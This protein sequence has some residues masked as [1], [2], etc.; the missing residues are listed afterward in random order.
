MKIALP[1]LQDAPTPEQLKQLRAALD[2]IV[3]N[4]RE[5]ISYLYSLDAFDWTILILYFGILMLLAILGTIRLRMVYQFWRYRNIKP[6]P[7]HRYK[8]VE[9]PRITVQLPLFNE[10]YVA[11][12][13]IDSI[14]SLDYPR[15][16]IEIQVLD[17]ST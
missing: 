12:R 1:L 2:P 10:L 3:R 16:L 11:E 7:L 8:E 5:N 9:L 13:L 15:N 17:D 4:G 14:V 6:E